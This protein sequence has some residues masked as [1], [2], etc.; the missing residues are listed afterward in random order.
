MPDAS[1]NVAY[2]ISGLLVEEG[3]GE[4]RS[5]ACIKMIMRSA[6]EKEY[7]DV[8]AWCFVPHS[9]RLLINDL[10]TLG[11]IPFQEVG[12]SPTEGFEFYIALSRNARGIDR[13]RLEILEI[14]EAELQADGLHQTPLQS[15]GIKPKGFLAR[16]LSQWR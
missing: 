14:I 7:I 3:G 9:F 1:F 8:H 11:M 5:Y 13:T 4:H 12:F 10:F 2:F 16:M 6:A 15:Q